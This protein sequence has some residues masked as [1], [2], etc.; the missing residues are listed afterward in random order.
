[1]PDW[2]SIAVHSE[3]GHPLLV[4]VRLA[5]SALLGWMVSLLYF[6]CSSQ[7][8]RSMADTLML[9]ALL[10]CAVTQV[11]GGNVA[12]AFSLVGALS[13]VRFRTVVHDTRDTAFVIFAV[14]LGMAVGS[15][16]YWVAGLALATV[17]VATALRFRPGSSGSSGAYTLT[18]TTALGATP[19]KVTRPGLERFTLSSRMVSAGLAGRGTGFEAVYRIRLKAEATPLDLVRD[20]QAQEGV[21][22]A[23]VRN[24][25]D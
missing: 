13:I 1:M 16:D 25:E 15:G 20:I 5:A 11:V 6:R 17:G 4:A 12:R 10:I 18:V 8:N 7:P 19:E 22:G 24:L 2:I 21:Q 23:Q 3:G 9:L 14:T